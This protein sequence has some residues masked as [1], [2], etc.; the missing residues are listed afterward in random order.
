MI[1]SASFLPIPGIETRTAWSWAMIASWRSGVGREP[2]DGQGDLGPD[3][4]DGQQQR[5][6]AELLSGPEAVQGLL[7]LA[8]EVERVQLQDLAGLR[9]GQDR[10]RG[11]DPVADPADLDHQRIGGDGADDP[12]TDAI[13]A[14]RGGY[15]ALRFSARSVASASRTARS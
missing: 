12:S 8:D 9:R 10:R 2:D 7:V 15:E 1:R 6:E 5:E 13:T 4:V 11:E 3:A 14:S